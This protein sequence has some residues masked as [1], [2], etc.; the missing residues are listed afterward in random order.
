MKRKR[1]GPARALAAALVLCAVLAQR[2]DARVDVWLQPQSQQI[3]VAEVC[4]LEAF[5]AT[6]TDDSLACMECFIAFD[7]TLLTLMSVEEG[8][9]FE[10]SGHPTFFDWDPLAPDTVSAVD[11]V[12]GYR[13]Y[14]L[15][16]GDLVRLVFRGD[17]AGVA[18]V[19]LIDINVWDIDRQPVPVV[20]DPSAWITIGDAT[21]T[22][23]SS[24]GDPGLSC[25]PNPFNPNTTI[26]LRFPDDGRHDVSLAVFAPS[27][28][29][30]KTLFSGTLAGGTGRFVWDGCND[31]GGPVATGVYFAVARSKDAVFTTKLILI[32]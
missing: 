7:A 32:E 8:T 10:D 23:N 13:T 16:P 17:Q 21:G 1:I 31:A 28:R 20:I 3:A 19:R 2:A 11:C 22:K 9:L 6:T 26:E 30:V 29:R 12:L 15:P 24:Y 18:S 27:G 14:F 4:T 25:F 5:V